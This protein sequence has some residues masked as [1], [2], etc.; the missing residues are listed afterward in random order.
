MIILLWSW[1]ILT[2]MS[3]ENMQEELFLLDGITSPID[4]LITSTFLFSPYLYLKDKFIFMT[5]I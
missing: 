5:K 2:K 1:N 4:L 3:L